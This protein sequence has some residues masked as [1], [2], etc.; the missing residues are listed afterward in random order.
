[1]RSASIALTPR[2]VVGYR[3]S[4]GICHTRRWRC[5]PSGCCRWPGLR[6]YSPPARSTGRKKRWRPWT[7]ISAATWSRWTR[8]PRSQLSAPDFLDGAEHQRARG[9]HRV[10]DAGEHGRLASQQA[11]V[12]AAQDALQVLEVAIDGFHVWIAAT[13]QDFQVAIGTIEFAVQALGAHVEH[14]LWR[15]AQQVQARGIANLHVPILTDGQRDAGQHELG[16]Q[17]VAAFLEIAA[18]G[19]LRHEIGGADEVPELV[20]ARVGGVDVLE[21]TL[22]TRVVDDFRRAARPGAQVDLG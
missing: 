7:R 8:P 21:R 20:I 12:L 1:M 9:R 13:V 2:I 5:A 11:P 17:P 3:R 10:L 16:I 18:V 19:H 6:P 15:L 14:E 4:P 22:V